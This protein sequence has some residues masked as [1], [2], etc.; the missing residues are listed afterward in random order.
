MKSVSFTEFR[1]EASELLDLVE[2]GETVCVLRHGKA[3]ARVV[4]AD[5]ARRPAAWKRPGLRLVAAGASLSRTLLKER[6]AGR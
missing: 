6:L 4:P 5:P 1:K 2:Q 3:V